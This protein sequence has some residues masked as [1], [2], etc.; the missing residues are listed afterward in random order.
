[1]IFFRELGSQYMSCAANDQWEGKY[2]GCFSVVSELGQFG[3]ASQR[4]ENDLSLQ[5]GG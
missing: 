1:M 2:S 5:V 4:S 3:T